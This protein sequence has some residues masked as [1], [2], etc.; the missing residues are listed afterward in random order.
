MF[1]SILA[2]LFVVPL[3]ALYFVVIRS[4]DRY[5]PEPW[6]L[7]FLCLAWGAVG[8][9]VPSVVGGLL[10]Q[11]ALASALNPQH[12]EQGVKLV[13]NTAAT[14][15]APLVEEPAKALGLL[16]IYAFSRR[17]VHETH[18]PLSGMVYGGIIGLGFTFTEDILY[19][20][21][22]AEQVGAAGFF[23][24]YFF[25]T[26]LLGLGHATFTAF[27]GLGFGLFVTSQS[28]WRWAMPLCGLLLAMMAHGGRNLFSSFLTLEG[29][30]ILFALMIHGLVVV[31]FFSLLVWLGFR[32]RSR[33]KNGLDGMVGGLITQA[34]Y[35]RIINPWMLLP[36]WN[37]INLA[38][39]PGGYFAV[40]EKQLNCFRLAFIRNRARNERNNPDVPP[41]L[42]LVEEE[43]IAAIKK[44]NQQGVLLAP[45]PMAGGP[46]VMS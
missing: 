24:V 22:A 41:V 34:E 32:D 28:G 4:V 26:I 31:L 11:E 45:E 37:L 35:D 10:G 43:A 2:V 8:A 36:G 5:M 44:A 42:D 25:R 21:G 16:A 27:T 40:R 18:G 17:R 6:W 19:I 13:E 9:V 39:L 3:V 33:V 29:A 46:P 7:L 12:T 20:V 38:G 15:L 14:F 23:G 30:G 1:W